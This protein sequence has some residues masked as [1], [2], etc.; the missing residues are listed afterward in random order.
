[1]TFVALYDGVV[2]ACCPIT[3]SHSEYHGDPRIKACLQTHHVSCQL[4]FILNSQQHWYTLRRFGEALPD[5]TQDTG[6]G[7]W[8]NL[9]SFNEHPVWIGKT[10]LGM[11]LQQAEEVGEIASPM[12]A[13]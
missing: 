9:N 1:M 2:K 8:F 4:A 6:V 3:T 12:Y 5:F 13:I 11:T 10:F 7:H